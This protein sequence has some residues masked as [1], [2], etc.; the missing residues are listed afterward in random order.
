MSRHVVVLPLF[1]GL[2]LSTVARAQ[3]PVRPIASL[4]LGP[5]WSTS[6]NVDGPGLGIGFRYS[7]NRGRF[8]FTVDY[9]NL[10]SK[11]S[12]GHLAHPTAGELDLHSKGTDGLGAIGVRFT[13]AQLGVGP[14][15]L[16]VALGAGAAMRKG[17]VSVTTF[18]STGAQFDHR[19][20][21]STLYGPRGE[22]LGQIEWRIGRGFWLGVVGGPT[23]T[24]GAGAGENGELGAGALMTWVLRG[25]IGF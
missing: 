1:L 14:T 6:D 23:V 8:A 18:D 22:L 9:V 10:G 19:E 7:P 20:Y 25:Q 5:E 3:E 24:L 2:M 12:R 13:A 17:K 4:E 15:V 11:E 16:S 21:A